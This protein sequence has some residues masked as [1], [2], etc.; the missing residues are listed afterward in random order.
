MI[1]A[2]DVGI[3][4]LAICVTDTNKILL[5]KVINISYNNICSSIIEEFD[6]FY[7]IIKGAVILIEKQMT[8]RMCI[9][10]AYI[11][12]YFKMK[13]FKEV[14]IYNAICKLAGTG[15][16]NTGRGKIRYYARKNAAIELCNEWLKEHPQ[17]E[18]VDSLWNSTK[19]KDD[20]ADTLC[21]AVS[22]MKS[23]IQKFLP[24][25]TIRSRKPT[26]KQN[27]SG[28]Y[29]KSNIKYF[30]ENNKSLTGEKPVISKK[31]EKCVL[32]FWK[33]LDICIKELGIT[34]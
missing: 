16:E 18:W 24:T 22:Y 30:L 6:D 13:D 11:E 12:M 14:I 4:N 1:V 15:K 19:K 20:L 33:S 21:M 32:K 31:L 9:I 26:I 27:A 28:R 17:E 29:S 5:W 10:Q 2:I 3:K 7:D 25:K 8:R 23:P 34:N